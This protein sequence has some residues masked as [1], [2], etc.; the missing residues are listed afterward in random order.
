VLII[1][2][3]FEAVLFGIEIISDDQ[4]R[5]FLNPGELKLPENNEEKIMGYIIS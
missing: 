5:I 3:K 1:Y 2:K 4:E